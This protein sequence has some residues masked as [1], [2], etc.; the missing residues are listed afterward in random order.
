[1]TRDD[2]INQAMQIAFMRE[3]SGGKDTRTEAK[4]D[5]GGVSDL[6]HV[7]DETRKEFRVPKSASSEQA[8]KM[9]FGGLLDRLAD[10]ETRIAGQRKFVFE[11]TDINNLT[12]FEIVASLDFMYNRGSGIVDFRK[13]LK[14]LADYR[15]RPNAEGH[16]ADRLSE[17]AAA[18]MMDDDHAMVGTEEELG[19]RKRRLAQHSM[20]RTGDYRWDD[21]IK[22]LNTA[23]QK[24]RGPSQRGQ[25]IEAQTE[26]LAQLPIPKPAKPGVETMA[27]PEP[28][29]EPAYTGEMPISKPEKPVEKIPTPEP[30]PGTFKRVMHDY[31][32]FSP[33]GEKM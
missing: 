3:S 10:G 18:V 26:Y 1:M 5:T 16:F 28:K 8:A 32:P 11:P 15:A 24:M 13:R 7:K 9:V 12:P 4:G 19:I 21:S 30:K 14:R 27:M 23:Q 33:E 22:D 20:F 6:Y 17:A 29:P 2:I 31:S 25:I